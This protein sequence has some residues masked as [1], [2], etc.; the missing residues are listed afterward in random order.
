MRFFCLPFAFLA[1]ACR[2]GGE[3][4]AATAP[5]A[6]DARPSVD[7][8]SSATVQPATN[9]SRACL[10]LPE[11]DGTCA[12]DAGV[13]TEDPGTLNIEGRSLGTCSTDPMTG[14]FRDG[15]CSTGSTDRGVHVVC[16]K[17][18]AAFLAFTKTEGNDLS[19]PAPRFRFPGLEPGDHWCLCAAR[20]QEALEAGV[21]PPVVV[22]ATHAR[23]LD[24]VKGSD[25]RRAAVGTSAAS[26][27]SG[28]SR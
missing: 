3:P 28:V 14:W 6:E 8:P 17:M 18:T 13:S 9:T 26:P 21:A 11:A 1:V 24:I 4:T 10:G 22:E 20:W 2:P 5:T 27:P 23:A 7:A 15:K 16:A 12:P 25:L 19:T